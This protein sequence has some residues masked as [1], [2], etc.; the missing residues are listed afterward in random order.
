M[1]LLLLH[2]TSA[3]PRSRTTLDSY[4]PIDISLTTG[5]YANAVQGCHALAKEV[6]F[7]LTFA[8]SSHTSFV[9][10]FVYQTL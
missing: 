1:I 7:D 4:I 9:Q 10:S 3:L 8:L 6:F 2:S 5:L